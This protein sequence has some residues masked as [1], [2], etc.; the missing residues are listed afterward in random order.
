MKEKQDSG[1]CLFSIY[2]FI[3]FFVK[4][5]RFFFRALFYCRYYFVIDSRIGDFEFVVRLQGVALIGLMILFRFR[6]IFLF[7]VGRYWVFFLGGLIFLM[8]KRKFF[9]YIGLQLFRYCESFIQDFS[10][11]FGFLEEV[12]FFYVGEF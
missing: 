1:Y 3:F 8:C 10:V 9:L 11:I 2:F 5:Y 7:W 12:F 4:E 6:Y